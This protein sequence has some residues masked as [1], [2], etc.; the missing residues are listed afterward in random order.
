MP[1]EEGGGGDRG[2]M[3]GAEG[4]GGDQEKPKPKKAE[5]GKN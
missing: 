5:P 1:E 4:K 3:P 2:E